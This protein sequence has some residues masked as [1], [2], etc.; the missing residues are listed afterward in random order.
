[1]GRVND[2]FPLPKNKFS[3]GGG[4]TPD[5][6][7]NLEEF[8]NALAGEPNKVMHIDQATISIAGGGTP[9]IT[10]EGNE[11]SLEEADWEAK[12]CG[13]TSDFDAVPAIS[14]DNTEVYLD[15]PAISSIAGAS[16][17]INIT[18]RAKKLGQTSDDLIYVGSISIPTVA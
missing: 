1:M 3:G 14:G 15:I 7:K 16:E 12:V 8:L 2:F 10:V 11:W 18:L 9:T 4:L 13:I 5:I 17:V 6:A